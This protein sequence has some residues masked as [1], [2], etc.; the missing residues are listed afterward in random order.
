[1]NWAQGK[2]GLPEVLVRAVMSLYEGFRTKVRA[3]SGLSEEF[4]V[5]I[6]V[7]QGSVLPPLI[8]AIV[9]DLR[10]PAAVRVYISAGPPK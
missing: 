2:K 8:F 6:G 4:V 7:H 10:V 9:V 1:M 3:G 5:R